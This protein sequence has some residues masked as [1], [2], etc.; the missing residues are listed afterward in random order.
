MLKAFGYDGKRC[1]NS[2]YA[3]IS[4]KNRLRYL[5]ENARRNRSL[6]TTDPG[7]ITLEAEIG[8]IY[9]RDELSVSSINSVLRRIIEQNSR[10][11]RLL[12]GLEDVLTVG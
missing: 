9:T 12:D 4:L 2:R 10:L 6:V 3:K 5:V 1:T 8:R 7:E 11:I